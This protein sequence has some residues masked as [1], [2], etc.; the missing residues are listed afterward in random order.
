MP[1]SGPNGTCVAKPVVSCVD[2]S[3]DDGRVFR[4]DQYLPA[5]DAEDARPLRVARRGVC[6]PVEFAASHHSP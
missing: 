3:A 2:R 4:V 6:H 1:S 5:G